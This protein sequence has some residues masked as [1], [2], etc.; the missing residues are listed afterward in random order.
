MEFAEFFGKINKNDP[1][2][3]KRR[4]GRF[5]QCC[6]DRANSKGGAGV[7]PAAQGKQD[8]NQQAEAQAQRGHR[9]GTE[10]IAQAAARQIGQHGAHRTGNGQPHGD[11]EAPDAFVRRL[12]EIVHDGGVINGKA[13]RLAD[14]AQI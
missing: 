1:G 5:A 14:L 13:D 10:R 11:G 12:G 9:T 8:K 2:T 4:R 6:A 3:P 7:G